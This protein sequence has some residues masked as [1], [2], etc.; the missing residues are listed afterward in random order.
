M[1]GF[2]NWAPIAIIG[3]IAIIQQ[4]TPMAIIFCGL[5]MHEAMQG[6]K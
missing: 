2:W 5:I 3:S 6:K 4:S 1:G